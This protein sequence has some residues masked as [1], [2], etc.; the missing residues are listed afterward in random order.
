MNR[1]TDQTI[2]DYANVSAATVSRVR[3]DQA[4]VAPDTVQRILK[5]AKELGVMMSGNKP[6]LA[7]LIVPD[8]TNPF[9]SELCFRFE[10]R[11]GEAGV[12]LLISSSNEDPLKESE[13]IDR[14]ISLGVDGMIY[15]TADSEHGGRAIRDLVVDWDNFPIVV[16]DRR[17]PGSTFDFVSVDSR[18]GTLQAVDHLVVHGHRNIGYIK[19]LVGTESARERFDAF[20]MA[21]SRNRLTIPP[22][23]IFLGNYQHSAGVACA[24]HLLQMTPSDRP[25]AIIAANDMMAIGLMQRLLQAGWDLPSKL[26]VIG[27]DDICWSEWVFPALTTIAQPIQQMVNTAVRLLV[28][29]FRERSDKSITRNA[30]IETLQPKLKPRASVCEPWDWSR[31]TVIQRHAGHSF[32]L[33]TT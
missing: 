29:R 9:F 2:A 24:E 21:M 14:F 11:F 33:Q 26:S 25:S 10:K 30:R 18:S 16:F 31:P 28:Q 15:I 7:G 23:W 8:S 27:F 3:N 17:L 6:L 13:I 22:E 32:Y 19:G 5:A 12:Q 1:V 4:N 20:D